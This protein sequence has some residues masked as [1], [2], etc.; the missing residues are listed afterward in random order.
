MDPFQ[1]ILMFIVLMMAVVFLNPM[2]KIFNM[3]LRSIIRSCR[4]TV[5]VI[6]N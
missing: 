3:S 4:K 2:F 5:Q 1:I 6:R